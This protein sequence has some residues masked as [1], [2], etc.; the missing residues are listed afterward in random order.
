VLAWARWCSRRRARLD[1]GAVAQRTAVSPPRR[2]RDA[3]AVALRRLGS[4]RGRDALGEAIALELARRAGP[5]DVV[6]QGALE[7]SGA[8]RVVF[9]P[10]P[11]IVDG[12]RSVLGFGATRPESRDAFWTA[13]SGLRLDG[14]G[15]V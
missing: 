14:R 13:A 12:R 15:R 11:V 9:R 4:R 8:L 1:R 3:L 5:T 10:A 7:D 6:V 2:R